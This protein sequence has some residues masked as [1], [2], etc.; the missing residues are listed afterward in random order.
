MRRQGQRNCHYNRKLRPPA[1]ALRGNMT[2]AEASLWKYVLRARNMK[3]YLFRRQRPVL[4][5]IA[6]FM[7]PELRLVIEIDGISHE[8][9]EDQER[10]RRRDRDLSLAG[11]RVMRIPNEDVLRRLDEVRSRVGL[12]RVRVT[13]ERLPELPGVRRT[14]REDDRYELLTSDADALVRA[15][16][17][18]GAPFADLEITNASLEEAFLSL[19]DP[20]A[21]AVDDGR[22]GGESR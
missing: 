1:H 17:L 7:C 14:S 15:L 4:Q 3:G 16:V 8:T 2:K 12:R 6:D 19:T 22:E 5:Y 21:R 13:A 11:Y 18:D 20:A 10:D 9:E